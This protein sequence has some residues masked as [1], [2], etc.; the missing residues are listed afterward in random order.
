[1]SASTASSFLKLGLNLEYLRGIASVSD[2]AGRNLDPFPFLREN[3]PSQRYAAV[4]VV[5]VLRSLFASLE[6]LNLKKSL[7]V[8]E[9]FRP[10]LAEVETY[11]G[12][13]SNPD[14]VTLLDHF[15]DKLIRIAD[16]VAASVK[17][18]AGAK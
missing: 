11:L 13:A 17:E 1:M 12:K 7:E 14:V 6:S 3:Q 8:A 2:L 9:G 5:T 16:D 10:M 4:R 15:A 18:E